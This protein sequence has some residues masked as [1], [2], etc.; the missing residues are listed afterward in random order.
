MILVGLTGGIGSGKSIVGKVFSKLNVPVYNADQEAR[1]LTESDTNI[2][3]ELTKLLGNHIFT[4]EKLNR[5]LM[6]EL[7]FNDPCLLKAVNLIIHPRVAI[8]F[9]HW[10]ADFAKRPYVVHESAI[11]FESGTYQLFDYLIL[12]TAPVETRIER[13][14]D[15]QGMTRDKALAIMHNQLPEKEYS[16]NVN[17]IIY[18]D[19]LTP[20][21]PQ[22][23]H[24]HEQLLHRN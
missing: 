2:R 8:H 7:V 21:L 19:G 11:L 22:I 16:D 6:A 1:L 24:I 20:V 3:N 4:G 13:V 5:T 14:L 9:K 12:I 23:L 18:N 10:C 17:Y 15:R